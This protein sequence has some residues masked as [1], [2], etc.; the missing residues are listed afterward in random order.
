MD[1]L[2]ILKAGAVPALGVAV[3]YL[4]REGITR[5]DL[6]IA[7]LQRQIDELRKELADCYKSS[8]DK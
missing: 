3:V 5:F 1:V 4:F 2:E 8:S 6:Q 7:Y